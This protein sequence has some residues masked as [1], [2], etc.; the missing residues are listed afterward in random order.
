MA[1]A[2]AAAAA[3]AHC[4]HCAAA[5]A[6]LGEWRPA[7]D[8]QQPHPPAPLGGGAEPPQTCT[9]AVCPRGLS[10]AAAVVFSRE[11]WLAAR[12]CGL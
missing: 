11:W 3:A 10:R 12:L 2:A 4:A 8:L 7:I 6:V 1:A 9:G 5:A